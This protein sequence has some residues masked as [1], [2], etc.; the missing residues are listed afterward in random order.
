VNKLPQNSLPGVRVIRQEDKCDYSFWL[1]FGPENCM[2]NFI[3][4]AQNMQ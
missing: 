2:A 4:D 1:I 3:L